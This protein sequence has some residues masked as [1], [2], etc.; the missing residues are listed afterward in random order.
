M[1][2]AIIDQRL[3]PGT[4]LIEAELCDIYGTSR[5]N[6][7][8]VLVRLETEGVVTIERN[9]GARIAQPTPRDAANIFALRKLVESEVIRLLSGKISEPPESRIRAALLE[10]QKAPSDQNDRMHIHHSGEFHVI[11]AEECGNA[12]IT[13]L[14]RR[15]V[16]RT[17]LVTQLF[18]NDRALECWHEEHLLLVD[19]LVSGA[20]EKA[21]DLMLAHLNSIE[22]ELRLSEPKEAELDLRNALLRTK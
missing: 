1:L 22:G 8:R 20:T 4:R 21:S 16:A 5:R 13:S 7:E 15:L 12:E 3:P 17:S 6:I 10:E 14:I 18:G 2:N 19:L 11:L 9:R